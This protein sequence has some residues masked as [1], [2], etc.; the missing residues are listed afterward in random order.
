MQSLETPGKPALLIGLIPPT[1]GIVDQY[2]NGSTG[3][4]SD[5]EIDA[6]GP[7]NEGI[8]VAESPALAGFQVLKATPKSGKATSEIAKYG[9]K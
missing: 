7:W 8:E 1:P 4:G 2:Y 9:K 5:E 3:T 6:K